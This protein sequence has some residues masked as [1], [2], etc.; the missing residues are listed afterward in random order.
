MIGCGRHV[1]RERTDPDADDTDK[2][3]N[4]Q[5]DA[6]HLEYAHLAIGTKKIQDMMHGMRV[7]N[8]ISAIPT[9]FSP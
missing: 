2:T 4:Q 6:Q 3:K 5:R 7:W 1:S 9:I 8:Q